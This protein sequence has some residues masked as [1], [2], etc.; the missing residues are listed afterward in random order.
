M[1]ET[2]AAMDELV[3]ADVILGASK[4]EQVE[5]NLAAVENSRPLSPELVAVCDA[6]GAKLRGVTPQYNR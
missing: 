1:E 2:L 5:Q 3:R 6:V 4:P